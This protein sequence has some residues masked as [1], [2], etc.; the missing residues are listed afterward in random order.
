MRGSKFLP[1]LEPDLLGEGMVLRV[2]SP[3]KEM[4]RLP[5]DWMTRVVPPTEEAG[6]VGTGFEV[7]GRASAVSAEAVKPWIAQLLA[8]SLPQ[9]AGLALEAAKA[10][11]LRTAFSVL[12]DVLAEQLE[13]QGDAQVARELE[14][15]G[16]PD[17]TVSLRRVGEW[18]SRTL[19]HTLGLSGEDAVLAER[20]RHQN[21]L[22][23]RLSE[24]GRREEALEAAKEAEEAYRELAKR[25]PDAFQPDLAMSLNNLGGRLSALGRREEA[26]PAFEEALDNIWPFLKR[27]PAVFMRN[28]GMLISGLL[29]TYEALQ[30]TPPPHI[31]ERVEEFKRLEGPHQ[32]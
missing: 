22:G 28:A 6:V 5:P 9:R 11:G 17:S 21:N 13:R 10:V 19:L 3:K 8:G 29:K 25:N 12:G 4:D 14:A 1:A 20:A 26:L 2:A 27:L 15:L 30:L 7:L 31:H 32:D 24:L 16:L 23:V 18:V